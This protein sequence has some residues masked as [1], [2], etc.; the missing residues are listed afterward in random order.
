MSNQ[1]LLARKLILTDLKYAELRCMFSHC[2]SWKISYVY[3][4]HFQT[5]LIV[6][7]VKRFIYWIQPTNY[8][9]YESSSLCWND[10]DDQ[11]STKYALVTLSLFRAH[12]SG[13]GVK[14][15]ARQK[16]SYTV[17]RGET[18][19]P[20]CFYCF[21][22]ALPRPRKQCPLVCRATCSDFESHCTLSTLVP[23][24]PL[25]CTTARTQM[26]TVASVVP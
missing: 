21:P 3:A 11:F 23:C 24:P 10:L 19:T 20:K 22:P 4:L 18:A 15:L 7:A 12:R 16:D 13:F 26:D 6:V 25:V 1:I 8:C 14:S 9:E 5:G 17:A 2:N